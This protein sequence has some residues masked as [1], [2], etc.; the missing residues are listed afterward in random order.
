MQY[1]SLLRW[2]DGATPDVEALVKA[3]GRLPGV[4]GGMTSILSGPT[5]ALV[6]SYD[7]GVII[8]FADEEG[9][10]AYQE[11]KDVRAVLDEQVVPFIDERAAIMLDVTSG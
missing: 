3:L 11:S 1:V 8:D 9:Y 10:R 2:K 4:V 7:F 6:N 5:S